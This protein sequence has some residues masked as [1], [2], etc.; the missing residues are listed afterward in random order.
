MRLLIVLFLVSTSFAATPQFT[1]MGRTL[2]NGDTTIYNRVADLHIVL[3]EKAIGWGARVFFR[4]RFIGK[5]NDPNAQTQAFEIPETHSVELKAAGPWKWEG[6]FSNIIYDRDRPVSY[7]GIYFD[8]LV[9]YDSGH[10]VSIRSESNHS[11]F[12][13]FFPDGGHFYDHE[14][15]RNRGTFRPL[16][17]GIR[18]GSCQNSLAG[19]A[20]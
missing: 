6:E 4:Y 10:E 16:N 5:H 17:I 20:S 13:L 19:G 12:T 2:I 9:R 1:I 18:A 11:E 3:Q 8:I 7:T 14:N 15:P